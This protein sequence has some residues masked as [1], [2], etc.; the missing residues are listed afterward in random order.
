VQDRVE[1]LRLAARC[2]G[3]DGVEEL[4]E[5]R[6]EPLDFLACGAEV[7]VEAFP[8]PYGQF[9][10]FTLKELQVDIEGV[11]RI[12][13][14]MGH[15][16]GQQGEGVEALGLQGLLCFRMACGVVADEHDVTQRQLVVLGVVDG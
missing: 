2:G 6:V 15:P 12:P 11:E 10:D 16:G 13:D 3:A 14:L 1:I 7:L 5:D 9:A 4:L 8:L